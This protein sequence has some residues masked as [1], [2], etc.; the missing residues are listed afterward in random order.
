MNL[1]NIE[2]LMNLYFFFFNKI[3]KL[4]ELPTGIIHLFYETKTD[5]GGIFETISLSLS[6]NLL[7]LNVYL[8]DYVVCYAPI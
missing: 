4:I 2:K 7:N 1:V 8:L 6:S 5:K 3:K